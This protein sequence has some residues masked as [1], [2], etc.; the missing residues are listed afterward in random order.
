MFG[1]PYGSVSGGNRWNNPLEGG[2]EDTASPA[3]RLARQVLEKALERGEP[4][5]SIW[6]RKKTG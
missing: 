5:T 1:H 3:V 6:N 2:R 4:A